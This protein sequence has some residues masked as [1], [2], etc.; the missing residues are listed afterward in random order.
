MEEKLAG[1]IGQLPAVD[2]TSWIG[3]ATSLLRIAIILA[4][5]WLA[6]KILER[7]LTSLR[8]R[9]ADRMTDP[10]VRQRA[11]TLTRVFRQLV[12]VPV[13]GLT[14]MLILSEPGMSLAPIL[15]ASGVGGVLGVRWQQAPG[16]KVSD[17]KSDTFSPSGLRGT[18]PSSTTG[19]GDARAP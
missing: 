6:V 17:L 14:I 5:A 2:V 8:T 4:R 12:A 3:P 1:L 19:A 16:E 10:N 15:G 11:E 7:R 18:G 13:G 9:L